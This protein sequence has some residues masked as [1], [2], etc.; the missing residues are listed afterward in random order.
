MSETPT[1]SVVVLSFNRP[2]YLRESLQAIR[3]QTYPASRVVVVDNHSPASDRVAELVATFP[4]IDLIRN[5]SNLGFTGGMNIGIAAATSKYVLLI[6]DDITTDPACL[7]EL[8]R[9]MEAD[10]RVGLCGAIMFNRG[11]GSV[12][13]AGGELSLGSRYG[14]RI[15]GAGERDAASRAVSYLPGALMLAR[16]D[17]LRRWGGFRDDFFMYYEDDELCLRV[18]KEGRAIVVAPRAKVSH[19]DP[20]PGPCPAWLGYVKVRNF[21]RLYLLHAPMS[22]LPG[23]LA[24]YVVWQFVCEVCRLRPSSLL[25]LAAA[26][27]TLARSPWLLRD[28]RRLSRGSPPEHAREDIPTPA[29]LLDAAPLDRPRI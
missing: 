15:F 29:S 27:D 24:R 12:R 14:K 16:L 8:V 18:L 23:F 13:C 21:F 28:R 22:V 20:E 17:D 9:C 6:E 1:V 5:S 19:F 10:P 25:V 2:Q 11:D 7:G 3:A 26:L 4:E